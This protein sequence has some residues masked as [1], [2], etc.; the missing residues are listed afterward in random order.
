MPS[1]DLDLSRQLCDLHSREI[2][3][4]DLEFAHTRKSRRTK[5]SRS[6]EAEMIGVIKEQVACMAPNKLA[7]GM[8]SARRSLTG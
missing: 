8:V 2:P 6:T 4:P 7:G 5:K 1:I 3:Q